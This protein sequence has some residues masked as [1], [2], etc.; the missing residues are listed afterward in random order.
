MMVELERQWI[1][2]NN[3]LKYL[4]NGLR[5]I[6]EIKDKDEMEKQLGNLR[7]L[8]VQEHYKRMDIIDAMRKL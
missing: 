7:V 5:V 3:F 8:Y 4:D 1:N 6:Q 2:S